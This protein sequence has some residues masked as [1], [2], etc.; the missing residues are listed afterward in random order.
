MIKKKFILAILLLILLGCTNNKIDGIEE[1]NKISKSNKLEKNEELLVVDILIDQLNENE[2]RIASLELLKKYKY[3]NMQKLLEKIILNETKIKKELLIE[4]L[5]FLDFKYAEKDKIELLKYLLEEK[6]YNEFLDLF[7]YEKI[8]LSENELEKIY[9]EDT[10][11]KNIEKI[12]F[13]IKTNKYNKL[14]YRCLDEKTNVTFQYFNKNDRN[15]IINEAEK[16]EKVMAE[17]LD[18]ITDKDY[19]NYRALFYN[20]L[21]ENKEKKR[22]SK[23]II[24][25]E[26]EVEKF[27]LSDNEY[28]QKYAVEKIGIKET[29]K[30]YASIKKESIILFKGL[31]L[32]ND[33]K[34]EE[35]ILNKYKE[36][37]KIDYLILLYDMKYMLNDLNINTQISKLKLEDKEKFIKIE[38]KENEDKIINTLNYLLLKEKDEL[39][40]I[41]YVN[42]ILKYRKNELLKLFRTIMKN[43]MFTARERKNIFK[44]LEL[45]EDKETKNQ[46]M[47]TF[48]NKIYNL[49]ELESKKI[50]S[51][52]K[53]IKYWENYLKEIP[54]SFYR[55][56]I[57]NKLKKYG[58]TLSEIRDET[59]YKS[60]LDFFTNKIEKM[61]KDLKETTSSEQKRILQ[62]DINDLK[63]EKNE[64][65][66]KININLKDKIVL[67]IQNHTKLKDKINSLEQQLYQMLDSS[68]KEVKQIKIKIKNSKKSKEKIA[69][70]ILVFY[71]KYLENF[72]IEKEKLGNEIIKDIEEL[73]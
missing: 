7:K 47:K 54:E 33:E 37:K 25:N 48:E 31:I 64:Y 15:W 13:L 6:K 3:V 43:E 29:K 26:K 18:V 46:I 52:S 51:V 35:R 23:I 49:A 12:F 65:N 45:I 61:E 53:K 14:L 62:K 69:E 32:V 40:R 8:V 44:K 34:I 71:A 39:S 19:Y 22:I 63:R 36:T 56:E 73:R 24:A 50:F 2:F 41:L 42:T 66:K 9:I 68:E 1:I 30:Y 20:R 27:L 58:E 21:Q 5:N 72:D 59:N 60:K 4:S 11:N 17:I 57:E 67:E 38:L 10:E 55:L 70:R 16:D 28:L